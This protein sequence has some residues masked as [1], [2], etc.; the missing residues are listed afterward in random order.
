[1][2]KIVL[3]AAFLFVNA[4]FH[5]ASAEATPDATMLQRV[6]VVEQVFE[7]I[8]RNQSAPASRPKA[9]NGCWQC[10]M[11]CMQWPDPATRN[12]CLAWCEATYDDC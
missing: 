4:V 9:A 1:M 8:G 5:S 3:A 7:E 10:Y 6:A 11:D 12:Q 2:K